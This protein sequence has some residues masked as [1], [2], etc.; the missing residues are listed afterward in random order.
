M[1][2]ASRW[3]VSRTRIFETCSSQSLLGGIPLSPIHQVY[4]YKKLLI[5]EYFF[6]R[7]HL[8]TSFSSVQCL[9]IHQIF[10]VGKLYIFSNSLKRPTG[11]VP[12]YTV[13]FSTL[14]WVS[15]MFS[16]ALKGVKLPRDLSIWFIFSKFW[17]LIWLINSLTFC[18]VINVGS[19]LY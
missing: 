8:R 19:Y 17:F 15:I 9:C 7:L 1:G 4:S 3:A 13:L 5:K 14:H 12:I 11:N 6:M 18:F 16:S 10:K 2:S